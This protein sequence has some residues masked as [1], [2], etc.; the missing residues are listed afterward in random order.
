M[1]KRKIITYFC[2]ML[3]L[4]ITQILT[5]PIIA[6]PVTFYPTN[7]AAP[8]HDAPYTITGYE[9][10]MAIRNEYG[11]G[12]TSGWESDGLIKFDISSIPTGSIIQSATLN[13]FYFDW[14]TSDPVGR[15]LT[16][17]RITSSWNENTVTWSN[18]PSYASQ[19]TS[20]ST[21]PSQKSVWMIWNVKDDVQSFVNGEANYGWKITD[22]TYW[23]TSNIPKVLLASKEHFAYNPYLEIIYLTSQNIEP[24][25]S[26]SYSP[27]TPTTD[28]SIQFSDKSTDDGTIVSRFWN[29]GDGTTST[30][31]NPT[32]RYTKSNI[33]T[34]SLEITDND[35]ATDSKTVA[36]S[37][38]E[39]GATPGFEPIIV[40][41]A[42]ALVLFW[43]RKRI[44][45]D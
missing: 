26:F 37:V 44:I 45:N 15:N 16:S 4:G 6:T 27:S 18:Q 31:K 43:K 32:H 7:D 33:Y 29:F 28:D 1:K 42:I 41:G 13:I 35:G 30:S 40:F 8:S 2:L 20:S 23:G 5:L 14:A 9:N 39:K 10:S 38:I 36:V 25:A 19:S 3:V 22:K 11:S 21:V 24:N 12:G 17:Y 34:V